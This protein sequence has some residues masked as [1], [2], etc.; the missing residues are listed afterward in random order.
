MAG[1]RDLRSQRL[2]RVNHQGDVLRLG[3]DWTD[4][5]L[6]KPQVLVESAYGMATLA[7][8]ILGR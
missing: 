1:P 2:R 4:E 8:L 7:P 5:D 3:M 6:A